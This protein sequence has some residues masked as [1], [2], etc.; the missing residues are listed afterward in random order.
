[1]VLIQQTEP[2]CPKVAK[3]REIFTKVISDKHEDVIAKFGATLAQ[4][5]LD[6]GKFLKDQNAGQS[7]VFSTIDPKPANTAVS[8]STRS[9]ERRLN[10]QAIVSKNKNPFSVSVL[11]L[12]GVLHHCGCVHYI[13]APHYKGICLRGVSFL[14]RRLACRGI[15]QHRDPYYRDVL[16][17]GMSEIKACP[18]HWGRS[19]SRT[20]D[21]HERDALCLKLFFPFPLVG[22]F[23]L[24]K[25]L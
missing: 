22:L 19:I 9:E 8:L 17:L 20:E 11:L 18:S 15:C 10:S 16:R 23:L 6:A 4:G 12:V 5:I 13:D 3:F 14:L 21:P 24:T 25:K 2:S 7:M 1:M